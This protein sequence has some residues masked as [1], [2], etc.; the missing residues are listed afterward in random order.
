MN[1][2]ICKTPV[3]AVNRRSI[4]CSL[5][6]VLALTG[7]AQAQSTWT[8]S[9]GGDWNTADNWSGGVPNAIGATANLTA[10]LTANATINL[11]IPATVGNMTIA[12]STSP[13]FSYIVGGSNTLTFND[14]DS[15]ATLIVNQGTANAINTNI[16][17]GDNLQITPATGTKLTLGGN[18]SG[19]RYIQKTG[20]GTLALQGTNTQV[21]GSSNSVYADAGTIELLSAGAL[22][23]GNFRI[24]SATVTLQNST[25]GTFTM[26]NNITNGG[27][28]QTL[29]LTGGN[30]D[31]SGTITLN[32]G[33]RAAIAAAA[34]VKATISGTLAT[35]VIALYGPGTFEITGN[36]TGSIRQIGGN[37]SS[38]VFG[39]G[40]G[41][42][43]GSFTTT[44][45]GANGL[46]LYALG[47][48]RTFTT[49]V[50][51]GGY[52]NNTYNFSG[53]NAMTFSGTITDAAGGTNRSYT[54]NTA[55]DLS[56]SFT[57][58]MPGARGTT[59]NYY[60]KTGDGLLVFSGTSSYNFRTYVNGGVLR[61]NDGVGLPTTSYLQL[62]G[63]VLEGSGTF[64]RALANAPATS[65]NGDSQFRWAA[66][67]GFSAHGG[68]LT[69]DVNGGG[70]DNLVWASTANFLGNGNT[71]ILGSAYANDVVTFQD[72][73]GLN[74]ASRTIRVDDNTAVTTDYA[75]LTGILSG[76]ASSALVKSGLGRLVLA[77]NNTYQGSTTVSAGTLLVTGIYDAAAVGAVTVASGAV[78]GGTGTLRGATTVS[79]GVA[80]GTTG[81]GTLSILSDVAW[82][83]GTAWAFNLGTAA[84]S[85]AAADSSSDADLLSLSGSFT[86]GTGTT[87][88]FDF[89]GSGGDGWYKLVD[90]G[91][92]TFVSGTNNAFAAT[93]LPTGKTASFVVDPSTSALY[94][95]VVPEPATIALAGLGLGLAGFALRRRW[96]AGIGHRG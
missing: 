46:T 5:A 11:D 45:E 82:N 86:Q 19:S 68:P 74:G 10:D 81:I 57:T 77:G 79:G 33:N 67:G 7:A 13:F 84:A 89:A 55:A 25:G 52:G 56:V 35:P 22:S 1:R 94:V 66:S 32:D 50:G 69:V 15:L 53:T 12:D 47:G 51:L 17:L 62:G 2:N 9:G 91:S 95:Q 87:F 40:T 36:V 6:A 85:L 90:Y 54:M 37:G 60:A 23:S 8:V 75:E 80:P 48:P 24:G 29:N 88:T 14:S 92:T 21:D 78:L 93:N 83:A 34:G 96:L 72:N 27:G 76:N 64:S 59:N 20:A 4:A 49:A 61:A 18:I 38:G 3:R 43:S 26:A 65:A 31:L 58:A 44:L 41:F 42:G 39:M 28:S 16:S 71:L 30:F 63:G 73:I 70:A